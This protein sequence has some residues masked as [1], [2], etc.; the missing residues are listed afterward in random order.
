MSP[1]SLDPRTVTLIL[2]DRC[3]LRCAHCSLG[4][5]TSY[6]G[7]GQTMQQSTIRRVIASL[8][9]AIY[10]MVVLAGG[11]PSLLPHLITTAVQACR[12]ANIDSALTTAPVWSYTAE[13]AERFLNGISQPDF[14]ILSLDVHHLEALK[15]EHYATAIMA[16]TSRG[17]YVVLNVCFSSERE[18]V[19]M[20][21]LAA[22]LPRVTAVRWSRIVP[23]GNALDLLDDAEEAVILR[24]VEDLERIPASCTA[25]NAL[26]NLNTELHACCWSGDVPRSPLRFADVLDTVQP[27]STMEGDH[28][29]QMLRTHGLIGSLDRTLKAT[30]FEKYNG[31]RFA[32]ECH[33]CKTLMHDE[34]LAPSCF[35]AVRRAPIN[36]TSLVTL[37]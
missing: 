10:N 17:I 8:D 34:Q 32:N 30:L 18:R 9:R 20:H 19:H 33:L 4:Y 6:H 5:S 23:T 26:V 16:A 36:E 37:S 28:H 1:H 2:N 22:A 3:P 21:A 25:G 14:M 12:E 35:G 13:A 27:F 11:E 15:L 29:F 31:K 7:S 24:S